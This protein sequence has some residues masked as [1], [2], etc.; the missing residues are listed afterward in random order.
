MLRLSTFNIFWF[1][2][3]ETASNSRSSADKTLISRVIAELNADIIVFQE[4][5]DT[6]ALTRVLRKVDNRDYQCIEGSGIATGSMRVVMTYDARRLRCLDTEELTESDPARAFA[7]RRPSV[8]A[9]FQSITSG[10]TLWCV[11]AHLKSGL[12]DGGD[13]QN[14]AKR[15][16]E[17]ETLAQWLACDDDRGP[18]FVLGDFNAVASHDALKAVCGPSGPVEL[19]QA[20]VVA[21]LRHLTLVTTPDE[22]W[23]TLLDR[24]V[25]DHVLAN[26]PAR[27][28]IL[29]A[30][31]IYAFDLDPL[32]AEPRKNGTP[33]F[34]VEHGSG[35][36]LRPMAGGPDR[37]VLAMYRVSD[38]RPVRIEVEKFV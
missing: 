38:H 30:A 6:D 15:L 24:V 29:N 1:P 19:T 22:T 2:Q 8:A 16:W 31:L 18:V 33:F 12:P 25:I 10:A 32:F 27:A 3:A 21:S 14:D 4:I 37:E 36:R 35:V 23:S 17:C 11:G 20:R 5:L 7:G 34:R 9:H 26:G 28:L 13:P